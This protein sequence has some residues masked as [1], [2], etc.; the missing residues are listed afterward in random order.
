VVPPAP[1]ISDAEVAPLAELL[2]MEDERALDP[3]RAEALARH[4]HPEVRARA[5]LAA[6]RIA[7]PAARTLLLAALADSSASVRVSAVFALGRL[8]DTSTVV[9]DALV[10]MLAAGDTAS[11]ETPSALARLNTPA[12][13]AAVHSLLQADP[14]RQTNL[15]LARE[16]L[17]ALWRFNPRPG[18]ATTALVWTRHPDASVRWA[19]TYNF[20]RGAPP[21]SA[22]SRLIELL[23]DADPLVRA[24]AARTLRRV[25]ADSAGVT[26]AARTALA[27]LLAD[28]HPHVRINAVRALGAFRE[29]ADAVS[30]ATLAADP[31]GNVRT[32]AAE[33]L[34][35]V[36]GPAAA[37]ALGAL[38]ADAT[39][40]LALRSAALTSLV[41]GD[42]AGAL[43]LA[44]RW[45]GA[46]SWLQRFYA[47][48][49]LGAVRGAAAEQA[50]RTLSRDADPRVQG[51]AYGALA[52]ADTTGRLDSFL[53]EGLASRDPMVRAAAA[54]GLGRN[55][56]PAYLSA[57]MQAYDRA[58]RDSINDAALAAVDALQR[59]ARG[60][61]PVAASFFLRFQPSRDPVVRARVAQHFGAGADSWGP[62]RPVRT[63]RDRAFYE[64]VIRQL[65][66]PALA[67]DSGPRVRVRTARGDI[68][69]ALAPADAP[70]TVHN[71]LALIESGL[72]RAP[73]LR[74]HRVVPNFV[75]QDGDPRGDGSGGPPHV[76]RDE[77]NLLRYGRGV[78]GMALSGP[79]TGGS[80]F[81]I[82]H[83]PQPH[84]DGGYTIFGRV[85]EGMAVADA[86]VQDDPILAI[87]LVR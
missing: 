13:F 15:P 33:A 79:D 30:I 18:A 52:A 25:Q 69:L 57:L 37:G 68:V 36:P 87:E 27:R 11:L 66:I 64:G 23:G 82:T 16:A 46:E 6:G 38:A 59:L 84:L 48:R 26:A 3:A 5:A 62:A 10:R 61:V 7:D 72:Y 9:V 42:T 65:V 51:E 71:F 14:A 24:T 32:A 76:I 63:G 22:A 17:L 77:I 1:A 20:A 56:S 86:I 73:G 53:L 31:D 29:P 12:G 2:R 21:A 35:T 58:Q 40:P 47:A 49:A 67:S 70:L 4:P 8:G 83:S 81:F 74:W 45:T 60:G 78:L 19:A 44:T 54:G 80:Q 55:G 39:A 50:L 75:L 43:A 28:P 41:R 85:I 34:A